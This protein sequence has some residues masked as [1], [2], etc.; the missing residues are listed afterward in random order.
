MGIDLVGMDLT[1]ELQSMLA[2]DARERIARLV[3]IFGLHQCGGVHAQREVVEGDVLD[4]F[5]GRL[6][7]DDSAKSLARRVTAP[8]RPSAGLRRSR[9]AYSSGGID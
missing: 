5:R 9:Y 7:R 8:H 6:Q 3:D 2:H 1:A 4:A